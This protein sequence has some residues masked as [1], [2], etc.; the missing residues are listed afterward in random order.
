[1]IGS[2]SQGLWRRSVCDQGEVSLKSGSFDNVQVP[3]LFLKF[4]HIS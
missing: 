1:M 3:N 4:E 2:I